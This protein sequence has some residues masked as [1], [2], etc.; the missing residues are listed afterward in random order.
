MDNEIRCAIK[1]FGP[2]FI[3]MEVVPQNSPYR[4]SFLDV[5]TLEGARHRVYFT[6]SG[7][8]E[9]KENKVYESFNSLTFA[10]SPQAKLQ[11]IQHLTERLECN[12]N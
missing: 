9:T 8:V 1:E 11:W 7:W 2:Y 3:L 10:I 4:S 12:T 5:H 6:A